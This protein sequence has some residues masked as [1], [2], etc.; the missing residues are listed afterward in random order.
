MTSSHVISADA[1]I[2]DMAMLYRRIV[3]GLRTVDRR[4]GCAL[5]DIVERWLLN[6]YERCAQLEGVSSRS[7]E[8]R[9]SLSAM[10]EDQIET[11]L[12]DLGELDV[13]LAR[14]L[15]AYYRGRSERDHALARDA[16]HW[17]RGSN[18]IPV[19]ARRRLGVKGEVG[20]DTAFGMLKGLLR[21]A[22]H[23][24]YRGTLVVMDEAET[25][26]RLPLAA[27]RASAYET[28]RLLVDAC[29]DNQL[30]D[31]LFVI[32][33]TPSFFEDEHV[34]VRSYQALAQRIERPVGETA[35]NARR[36]TILQL[37]GLSAARLAEVARKVRDLHARAFEYDAQ[38]RLTDE[39]L[40]RLAQQATTAFG[41]ETPRVPRRF[42]R[43]V[44]YLCDLCEEHPEF[45]PGAYVLGTA[46]ASEPERAR[47]SPLL[48]G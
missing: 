44:V 46:T 3:E 15:V 17:L 8:H 42:L 27:Q 48:H 37:G 7:R 9:K 18:R 4:T 47:Q 36:S 2:G 1:P 22:R 31:G 26:L 11:S 39:L 13:G 35:P 38:R 34:G 16:L 41:E 29:G 14:A 40:E 21:L 10:V 20:R 23:A 12:Q 24:G 28:L 6:T 33:G 43:E 5:Q 30:A 25:V 19:E 32:T 45:D